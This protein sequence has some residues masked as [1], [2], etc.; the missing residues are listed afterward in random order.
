MARPTTPRGQNEHSPGAGDTGRFLPVGSAGQPEKDRHPSGVSGVSTS[1]DFAEPLAESELLQNRFSASPGRETSAELP[2]PALRVDRRMPEQ[3]LRATQCVRYR[4]ILGTL[5]SATGALLHRR[6]PSIWIPAGPLV[7]HRR[8]DA[9]Y[10]RPTR[11]GAGIGPIG[12]A[13]PWST[14]S[15]PAGMGVDRSSSLTGS[16]P[17][18]GRDA[19]TSTGTFTGRVETAGLSTGTG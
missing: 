1:A 9:A 2:G 13:L 14:R 11:S 18:A 15:A 16:C 3:L 4:R 17:W 10:R 6:C 12:M 7:S 5:S 8:C 19:Q